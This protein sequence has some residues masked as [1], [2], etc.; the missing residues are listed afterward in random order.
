MPPDIRAARSARLEGRVINPLAYVGSGAWMRE[1]IAR[2]T[3][4]V[5]SLRK[6]GFTYQAISEIVG[7]SRSA[8]YSIVTGRGKG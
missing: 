7:L 8:V 5:L 1:R 4:R 2:L 6:R 3:P